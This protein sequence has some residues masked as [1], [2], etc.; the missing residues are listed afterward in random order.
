[1]YVSLCANV[2]IFKLLPVVLPGIGWTVAY[3]VS[4]RILA[5][6][7]GRGLVPSR[8][9][10]LNKLAVM[11]LSVAFCLYE[12][13]A[14]NMQ[15]YAKTDGLEYICPQC[16][17]SNFKK[18]LQKTSNGYSWGSAFSSIY[19]RIINF[20]YHSVIECKFVF[21]ILHVIVWSMHLLSSLS[22]YSVK[23]VTPGVQ[24]AMET[25]TG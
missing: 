8:Y 10:V 23:R 19:W 9:V 5:V 11:K 25:G 13:I 1:M 21:S 6:T 15:D 2:G 4:G 16:S 3:V 12:N 17:I 20:L 18:K 7:E 22:V 24:S 14:L